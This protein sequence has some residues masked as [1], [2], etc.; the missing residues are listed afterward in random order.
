MLAL[1]QYFK[2]SNIRITPFKAGPDFLDPMWH[3]L[4]SGKVS[5]NLDTQMIGLEKSRQLINKQK[6]QTDIALIEGVMGLF[7][8]RSGVGKEGSGADLAKGL[9][10]PVIL[11]VNAKGMSGSIVPL[12]SGFCTYAE[13][14]GVMISGI[15]ANR[16]GSQHH[17]DLLKNFLLDEQLPALIGW[18][19]K[20]APVLPERHLGLVMPDNDE[21]P[22]FTPF[23]HVDNKA[24]LLAFSDWIDMNVMSQQPANVWS[25]KKIA[26]I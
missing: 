18:M 13:K 1:L 7:D 25:G 3:R 12:V 9:A 17:A 14:M 4:V 11:V 10:C 5:Y 23:F 22:D 19:E 6:K 16:V 2:K 8:G 26:I 20:Q 24:L 21:L 15:I